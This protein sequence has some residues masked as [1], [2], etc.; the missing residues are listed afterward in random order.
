MN[1]EKLSVPIAIVLAGGLI[2]FALYYSNISVSK[3]VAQKTIPTVTETMKP[4]SE[5]DHILGNP[6]AEVLI[7]EYSDTECPYCKQFHTTLRRIMSEY[8][9]DGKVAWVYRH[10]PIESLHSKSKKEAESTE[11]AKE[12]GGEAKFWEYT[13]LLYDT[14]TSNDTL[15]PAKLPQMAKTVGLD[16]DAFNTCL[17]S[18]KYRSLVDASYDDA[19]RAGGEGTPNS[20]L[21]FKDGTKTQIKGA[22]PYANL[23][24]II[25]ASLQ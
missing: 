13:N 18:G 19:V 7:V 4:V 11:C 1:V 5:S 3:Q 23:K 15:D 6:N 21:I 10:F 2:A 12:Q 14:T 22:Q 25:D 17:D 24:A 9:T 20:F 16:V 8:G